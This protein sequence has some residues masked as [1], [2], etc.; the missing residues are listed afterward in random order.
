MNGKP[1]IELPPKNVE[2]VRLQFSEQE[3]NTYRLFESRSQDR[4][5]RLVETDTVSK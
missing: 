3:R 5:R 4:F 2:V 1:I